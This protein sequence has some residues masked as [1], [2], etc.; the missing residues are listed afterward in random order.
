MTGRPV[1][2]L[3]LARRSKHRRH[4]CDNARTLSQEVRLVQSKRRDT[5]GGGQGSSGDGRS[6]AQAQFRK[7]GVDHAKEP[8]ASRATPRGLLAQNRHSE[9]SVGQ[10]SSNEA[11][12]SRG[13]VPLEEGEQCSNQAGNTCHDTAQ[14]RHSGTGIYS[15]LIFSASFLIDTPDSVA[16]SA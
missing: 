14:G 15:A 6:L 13:K 7:A 12:S 5:W 4:C 10:G 16:N 9:Q 8:G 3:V 2:S 11:D 1:E